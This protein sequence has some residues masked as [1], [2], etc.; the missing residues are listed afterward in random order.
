[1]SLMQKNNHPAGFR[2]SKIEWDQYVNLSVS[3][4]KL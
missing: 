2:D 4:I 1:M 3:L